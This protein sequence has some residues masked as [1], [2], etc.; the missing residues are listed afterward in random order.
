MSETSGH[1]QASSCVHIVMVLLLID[2]E[3]L[4]IYACIT[5]VV[6]ILYMYL[7]LLHKFD[8]KFLIFGQRLHIC[9]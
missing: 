8:I 5:M 6:L 9:A 1:F 7:P 3:L 4:A 2:N